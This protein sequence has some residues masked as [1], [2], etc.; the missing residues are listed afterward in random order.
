M[1]ASMAIGPFDAHP[2]RLAGGAGRIGRYIAQTEAMALLNMRTAHRAVM[3]A[4]R[5]PRAT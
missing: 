3:G 2:E 4:G 5:D 1:P